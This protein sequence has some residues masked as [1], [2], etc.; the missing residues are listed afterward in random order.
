MKILRGGIFLLALFLI[1]FG[2]V[3]GE[4]REVFLKAAKIC[5]ECIGLG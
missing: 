1:A 2:L 5:L 4:A 3:Q